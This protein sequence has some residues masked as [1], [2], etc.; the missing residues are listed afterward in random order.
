LWGRVREGG[1]YS[2]IACVEP[3]SPAL[4]H[5]GEREHAVA[6]ETQYSNVA[7]PKQVISDIAN[8]GVMDSGLAQER[9]PECQSISFST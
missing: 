8:T 9:A 6:V 4:S 2:G 7:F 1:G 5:K 3:L